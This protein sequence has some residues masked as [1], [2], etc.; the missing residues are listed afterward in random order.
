MPPFR[1]GT[2]E[3]QCDSGADIPHY[4]QGPQFLNELSKSNGR[5]GSLGAQGIRTPRT[6]NPTGWGRQRW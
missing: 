3:K 5:N 4:R 1:V 2:L 6:P